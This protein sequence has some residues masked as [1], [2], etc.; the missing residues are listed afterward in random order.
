MILVIGA[1]GR[2]GGEVLAQLVAKGVP[3]RVL[4]QHAAQAA[5]LEAR[6]VETVVGDLRRP[7]TLDP[8]FQ[9]VNKLFIVTPGASDQVVIQ[10]N[11]IDAAV[12]AGVKHVVKVSDLGA[13]PRSPLSHARWNWEIEQV[14]IKSGLPYTILRPQFFMQNFLLVIAPSVA[15]EDAFFAPTG[16]GRVPFVDIRDIAEVAVAALTDTGHENRIYDLTGPEDLSFADVARILTNTIQRDIRF[17]DVEPDAARET[18]VRLGLPTWFANDLVSLFAIV[19]EGQASGVS[20]TVA[21]V[22]HHPARSLE[23]FLKEHREAFQ[24]AHI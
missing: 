19:K 10:S 2:V 21:E 6:G 4:A 16:E 14:L 7:E 20:A 3:L 1:T 17:E 12:R 22:T 24:T 5:A 11:A 15:A 9:G 18:L 8:A 23:Q 13:S